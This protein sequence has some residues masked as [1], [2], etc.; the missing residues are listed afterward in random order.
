M[1]LINNA[2]ILEAK[3][4]IDAIPISF[5]FEKSLLLFALASRIEVSNP[6][7]YIETAF[8]YLKDE[9]EVN[10]NSEVML[11]MRMA[12]LILNGNQFYNIAGWL[13]NQKIF[14]QSGFF[15]YIN[16]AGDSYE[17][18]SAIIEHPLY[19]AA[20]WLKAKTAYWIWVEQHE[21]QLIELAD[22][23]FEILDKIFP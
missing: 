11:N 8:Y 17:E 18:A 14:P 13:W 4:I 6:R 5:R 7:D 10:Q 22:K 21:P 20:T 12:E 15:N 2:K 16:I 9:A 19:L 1:E 3:R 23:Y